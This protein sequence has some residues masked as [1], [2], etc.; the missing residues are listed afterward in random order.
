MVKQIKLSWGS[1][2]PF[3]YHHLSVANFSRLYRALHCGV[4]SDINWLFHRNVC[5][6]CFCSHDLNQRSKDSSYELFYNKISISGDLRMA[7][8]FDKRIHGHE[9]CGKFGPKMF[10]EWLFLFSGGF[11]CFC[12]V[13][14]SLPPFCFKMFFF[15]FF[16]LRH[17]YLQPFNVGQYLPSPRKKQ[18]VYNGVVQ[19]CSQGFPF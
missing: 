10:G 4:S 13:S 7:S 3:C 17:E 16:I 12:H 15:L 19:P 9:Q 6:Q 14:R 1:N 8:F 5:S 18:V 2:S 11:V